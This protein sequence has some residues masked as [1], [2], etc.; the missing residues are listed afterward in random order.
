MSEPVADSTRAVF[1]PLA[2]PVSS[3]A[4]A[5]LV[6]GD[7]ALRVDPSHA[8]LEQPARPAGRVSQLLQQLEADLDEREAQLNR[9]AA[10]L[11]AER[12]AW[13]QQ[14]AAQREDLRRAEF[15]LQ[16]QRSEIAARQQELTALGDSLVEC[17]QQLAAER[18]RVRDTV[19]EELQAERDELR[20][21][22]SQ[23]DIAAEFLESERS[24]LAR[25]EE[26][27]QE[28]LEQQLQ[29]ERQ[30]LWEELSQEWQVRNIVFEEERAA[31]D[32]DCETLRK[33]IDDERQ[34]YQSLIAAW[35]QELSHQ[36]ANL[37]QD[38]HERRLQ[39][40]A[41]WEA[42]VAQRER[43]FA[44]RQTELQRERVLLE[45]RL[46][47]QQEHLDKV[48]LD[49]ERAQNEFRAERQ[50]ERQQL[51]DDARQLQRRQAQ[52]GAYRRTLEELVRAIDREHDTVLKC[53]E[54]WASTV[55]GDRQTLDDERRLWEEDRQRQQTEL[56]RQ[57]ELIREQVEQLEGRRLRL[58]RLRAEL[59][60]THRT[61]LELRLAVEETWAQIAHSTGSDEDARVK[62]EQSRQ[63][64]V[65]Y[66]QQLHDAL[67]DHRREL[68]EQ[69]AWFDQQ[70][71]EF[72]EE[73]QTVL[74]WLND[75]DE[76]LRAEEARQLAAATE[77]ATHDAAWRAARD[78][79]LSEKLEAERV[80]RQ[81]VSQLA[82]VALGERPE[83]SS[84]P[85]SRAA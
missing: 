80:I 55:D 58:E 21:V 26:Q 20:Q 52:L 75:R 43:E 57:Q 36:R 85:S 66:Y 67:E 73:R 8:P 42:L 23:L 77:L 50:R 39:A 29:S 4:G 84:L 48:R 41:D 76:R 7:R 25:E 1:V 78:R 35:E 46:R 54:A 16:E 74:H 83:S 44:E 14:Q 60:D 49:L 40:E 33:T 34:R 13:R 65:L 69:L 38:L 15:Q 9:Q 59:E 5:P 64:L 28:R 81:L 12:L 72:H 24:R 2:E 82:D 32:R 18:D 51:E 56:R 70:R 37:A 31:W 71:S 22:R 68:A 6:V 30:R 47:F 63:A 61:T 11:E 10:Q 62:V 53:R 3:A 27:L 79:W 19:L 45:N 17:Q